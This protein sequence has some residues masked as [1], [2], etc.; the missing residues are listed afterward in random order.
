M[1]NKRKGIKA[2][3]TIAL[4]L[5]MMFTVF[6]LVGCGDDNEC[7]M[8]NGSGYYDHKTCPACKGSGNSDFDP[9]EIAD[10]IYGDD[11][12]DSNPLL[13]IIVIGGGIILYSYLKSGN[14]QKK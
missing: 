5:V 6:M 12:D 9:Y 13:A 10:D 14:K 1:N 2:K 4:L 3:K 7:G 11:D 8:C